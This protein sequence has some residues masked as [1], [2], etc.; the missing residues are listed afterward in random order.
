MWGV[1]NLY[2]FAPYKYLFFFFLIDWLHELIESYTKKIQKNVVYFNALF[3]LGS[4]FRR[5]AVN[6]VSDD[7]VIDSLRLSLSVSVSVSVCLSLSVC[8]FVCLSVSLSLCQFVLFSFLFLVLFVYFTKLLFACL[9]CFLFSMVVVLFIY[10]ACGALLS[11]QG[12]FVFRL[13][14]AAL[15]RVYANCPFPRAHVKSPGPEVVAAVRKQGVHCRVRVKHQQAPGDRQGAWWKGA[16]QSAV[17]RHQNTVTGRRHIDVIHHAATSSRFSV[18]AVLVH[19][20]LHHRW[21]PLF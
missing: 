13:K 8:L 6:L 17:G 1:Y 14:I 19:K 11:F 9:F 21:S 7:G 18:P 15:C 10:F 16:A 3:V 4:C 12:L 5:L 2:G 20:K